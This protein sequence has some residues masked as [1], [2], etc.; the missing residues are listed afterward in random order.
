MEKRKGSILF[1]DIH[2][3]TAWALKKLLDDLQ[4]RGFRVVHFAP[5]APATTLP[6]YAMRLFGLEDVLSA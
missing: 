5:K 2:P 3:S 4:A 1:H 6:D